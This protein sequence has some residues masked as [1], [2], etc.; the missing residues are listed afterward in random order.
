MDEPALQFVDW[1]YTN[2]GR[3]GCGIAL[4]IMLTVL[5]LIFILL[6]RLP[7]PKSVM[8]WS[9]CQSC[10]YRRRETNVFVLACPKHEAVPWNQFRSPVCPRQNEYEEWEV[11]KYQSEP[12]IVRRDVLK[13]ME[14][15]RHTDAE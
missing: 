9:K 8:L 15:C 1:I 12:L 11:I 2:C 4:L 7:E 13:M 10:R 5:A 14:S 3:A 6:N